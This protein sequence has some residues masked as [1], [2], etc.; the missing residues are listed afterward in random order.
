MRHQRL[1]GPSGLGPQHQGPM[2]GWALSVAAPFGGTYTAP[3]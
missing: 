2:Q 3:P 1:P